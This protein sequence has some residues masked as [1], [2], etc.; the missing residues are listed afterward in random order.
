MQ[1]ALRILTVAVL[2]AT[3][4]DPA[5]ADLDGSTEEEAEQRT[6]IV[7]QPVT[8]GSIEQALTA[9]STIEAERM[10][11][12]HA[13]STG[14]LISFGL[15]EGDIL[16]AGAS[17]GRIKYD[18]QA[19]TLDRAKTSQ[20]KAQR[21]L[22]IVQRLHRE[23]HA[24]DDELA[25]AQLA[26]KTAS[27]DVGDSKR[28]IRNTRVTAPFGG[29]VTER[30]VTEG[31]FV[32]AGAQLITITDFATLVARV[33]VPERELDRISVGQ[34]ALV[35]GKAARSRQ[36]QGSIK[37][38]APVVDATTGT[39][40]VTVGLPGELAGGE[41]GFLPGMYAEVRL[42]TE[43]KDDVL[44]V[45]KRALV[46]EDDAVYVFVVQD[47]E[48]AKRVKVE[49]GLED[50]ERAEVHSGLVV[51]DEVVVSGQAGLSDG[52]KVSR[53]DASGEPLEGAAAED[54]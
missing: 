46:R 42:T 8:R 28:N 3:A 39:V 23:G 9:A 1:N 2:V 6:P 26:V 20:E 27:L 37:R 38:I 7:S 22:E 10:V 49:L 36:G 30:F 34:P 15:E 16:K 33:Y 13:E 41:K 52:G 24:S 19:A 12:V 48:T 5:R 35:Q 18:S 45:S 54:G 4:C 25:T 44:L 11:T 32:S 51:G 29:T 43:R 53:V 21:D 47:D 31:S 50:A 14:R 17:V 40:K